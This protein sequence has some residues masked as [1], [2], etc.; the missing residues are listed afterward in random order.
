MSIG[1]KFGSLAARLILAFVAIALLS[2]ATLF[3]ISFYERKQADDMAELRAID[4][5]QIDVMEELEAQV[6]CWRNIAVGRRCP[7]ARST[8]PTAAC[9]AFRVSPKL[10]PG[11]C[12]AF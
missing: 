11:R 10:M 4:Q 3:A 2:S 9:L 1:K 6:A 12:T 7:M 5:A 8:L